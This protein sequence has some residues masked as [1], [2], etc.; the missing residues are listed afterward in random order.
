MKWTVPNRRLRRSSERGQALRYQLENVCQRGRLEALVL[1]DASGI[2]LA[3]AGDPA[4]CEELGAMAPLIG[5]SMLR[6]VASPLLA[7]ADVAVRQ[8]C[9]LGQQLY[10]ASAGGNTARDALLTES[11]RGIERILSAN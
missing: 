7:G 10:L 2:V 9:L 5:R 3:D 11:L 1:A 8:I 4:V 6:I